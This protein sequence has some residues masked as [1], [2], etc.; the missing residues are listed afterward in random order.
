MKE[1][2]VNLY[3]DA[4]LIFDDMRVPA[5]TQTID[6]GDG[7]R[8]VELCD[9]ADSRTFG[10]MKRVYSEG[11][12]VPSL[13]TSQVPP[14]PPRRKDRQR[15]YRPR[16]QAYGE[17]PCRFC[18]HVLNTVQSRGMHEFRYHPWQR[19]LWEKDT[20]Y[21][22]TLNAGHRGKAEKNSASRLAALAAT[23]VSLE[24][25]AARER[26]SQVITQIPF[27][28]EI[29]VEVKDRERSMT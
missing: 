27:L 5:T 16:P 23:G 19:L 25:A 2:S 15:P 6:L 26:E 14:E 9:C 22:E 18:G 4:H 8:E 24:E 28:K 11:Q 1:I 7:P 29:D 17:H 13:P 3:C 21:L 20:N 10:Q 12:T